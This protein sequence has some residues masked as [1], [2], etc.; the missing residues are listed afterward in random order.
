MGCQLSGGSRGGPAP[1]PPPL[2]LDETEARRAEKKIWEPRR[3]SPFSRG[4][5]FLRARVWF[6]LLSLRKNGDYS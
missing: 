2:F 6:T 5:I 4:L 3:V 1:P